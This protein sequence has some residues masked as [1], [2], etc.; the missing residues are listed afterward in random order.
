MVYG[1][2]RVPYVAPSCLCWLSCAGLSCQACIGLCTSCAD[3]RGDV[4]H[5]DG[6]GSAS[7]SDSRGWVVCQEV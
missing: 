6:V 5:V 2:C 3:G 4:L 1:V 7:Q